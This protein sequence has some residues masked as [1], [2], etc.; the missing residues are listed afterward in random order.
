MIQYSMAKTKILPDVNELNKLFNLDNNI[1]EG[2]RW[3]I[4]RGKFKCCGFPAGGLQVS[5]YYST[6][7]NGTAYLNHRIVYSI[8]H[9][10]NL[11]SN[12]IIDH[13][14]RNS[15][16]NNPYNLRL[17]SINQN[18]RNTKKRLGT[19]SKFKGVCQQ[20]LTNKFLAYI[21][22]DKRTTRLGSFVLESDAA[23]A[24]NNYILDN[25]L[26]H[27]VLNIINL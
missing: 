9:N 4:D 5:Q 16:N 25:G 1:P 15:K 24:Y 23:K 7:I 8:F 3:S 22:V 12:Q 10:T 21:T 18:M 17:V 26:T 19:S 27:F 11:Q 13:I 2:I 20:K 6:K 14:D